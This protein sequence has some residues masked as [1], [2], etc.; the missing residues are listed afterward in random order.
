MDP[1]LQHCLKLKKEISMSD[2]KRM[3]PDPDPTLKG[4]PDPYQTLQTSWD[5]IPDLGQYLTF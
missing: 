2:P 1:D 4:I 3:A 5:A